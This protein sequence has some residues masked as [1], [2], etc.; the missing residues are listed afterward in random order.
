[1]H[2]ENRLLVKDESVRVWKITGWS[3][4]LQENYWSIQRN[5]QNIPKFVWK[6][7]KMST[8]N[9]LNLETQTLG[10]RPIMPKNLP[11][12]WSK[13]VN[14]TSWARCGSNPVPILDTR[15]N[16]HPNVPNFQHARS[17]VPIYMFPC[18]H[19]AFT[20]SW[21]QCSHVP[22]SYLHVPGSNKY[23]PMCI[24]PPNFTTKF[25]EK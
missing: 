23:V 22:P 21:L 24:P 5:L 8:C 20:W 14:N 18:V 13:Y 6:N 15:S 2:R 17:Y 4:R 3:S 1:M 25:L 10:G 16:C 12:H 9:R 11:G 19:L 7:R